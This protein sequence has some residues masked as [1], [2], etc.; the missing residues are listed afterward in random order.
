MKIKSEI[1]TK[2]LTQ[3]CNN[4]ETKI[5][6]LKMKFEEN[7]LN[8]NALNTEKTVLAKAFMPATQ[9]TDYKPIGNI[10]S[11]N[12]QE[13]IKIFNTFNEM[14]I[15]K[16]DALLVIKEGKNKFE[17][18]LTS[19]EFVEEGPDKAFEFDQIVTINADEIKALI[20][21]A[22]VNKEFILKLKTQKGAIEIANTG[23]YKF[24]KLID[25]LEADAGIE[26]AVSKPFIDAIKSFTGNIK[27]GLKNNYPVQILN[28]TEAGMISIIAA[29]Y[30]E[31]KEG[32]Q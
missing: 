27:L 5:I 15:E 17:T 9:F 22:A 24:T 8:I 14:E 21:S 32:A 3:V 7:G 23:K 26:L 4:G 19:E 10:A 20:D 29:P 11:E 28:K 30:T 18:L 2:F 6:S 12:I 25:S 31:K 1:L 13:L 16:Q